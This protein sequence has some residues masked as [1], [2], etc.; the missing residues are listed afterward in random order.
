M[1]LWLSYLITAHISRNT[2]STFQSIIKHD[3]LIT[4]IIAFSS[5]TGGCMNT[6][7]VHT[8][9][10]RFNAAALVYTL[11]KLINMLH[12]QKVCQPVSHRQLIDN[13][14]KWCFWHQYHQECL[15]IQIIVRLSLLKGDHSMTRG[16]GWKKLKVGQEH[17]PAVGYT[18]YR[19]DVGEWTFEQ[20]IKN[21]NERCLG[22]KIT[23]TE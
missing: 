1:H 13:H 11:S 16:S 10:A 4:L 21:S 18:V 5:A 6:C 17:K 23:L 15:D 9:D 8:L 20:S 12:E 22:Q 19:S 14:Q 7:L 2:A 3:R